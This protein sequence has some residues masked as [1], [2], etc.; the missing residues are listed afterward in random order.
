[1]RSA[2]SKIYLAW[3]VGDQDPYVNLYVPPKWKLRQKFTAQIKPPQGFEHVATSD[4]EWGEETSVFKSIH[5]E[6]HV[7]SSGVFDGSGFT[8]AIQDAAKSLVH[9]E[10]DIDRI[11]A[12]L[13]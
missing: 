9:L 13:G 4:G 11:L 12:R 10:G 5:Y 6:D 1:V 2:G 8:K 7:N 3:P